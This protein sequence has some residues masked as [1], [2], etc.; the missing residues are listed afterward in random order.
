V[1]TNYITN[2]Q[3]TITHYKQTKGN[4]HNNI[5]CFSFCY[6][7]FCLSAQDALLAIVAACARTTHQKN[8]SFSS[9]LFFFL[10]LCPGA[11]LASGGRS[12]RQRDCDRARPRHKQQHFKTNKQHMLQSNAYLADE[13]LASN[14]LLVLIVH[15]SKQEQ[16]A[17]KKKT[18][19]QSSFVLLTRLP[20]R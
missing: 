4:K 6:F 9:F 16:A 18:Q 17:V 15:V 5:I 19:K 20:A 11:F 13:A 7:C 12:P 8:H 14:D 10:S 1:I 2:Q 3:Q